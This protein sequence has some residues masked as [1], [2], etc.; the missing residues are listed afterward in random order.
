M[1]GGRQ[2]PKPVGS[3]PATTPSLQWISGHDDRRMGSKLPHAR[4]S[5]ATVCSTCC[6]IVRTSLSCQESQPWPWVQDG[7][8]GSCSCCSCRACELHFK[9]ADSSTARCLKRPCRHVALTRDSSKASQGQQPVTGLGDERDWKQQ[10]DLSS[11]PRRRERRCGQ[12]RHAVAIWTTCMSS[13]PALCSRHGRPITCSSVFP[14]VVVRNLD[15]NALLG[16]RL[17]PTSRAACVARDGN[18]KRDGLA[19]DALQAG[20]SWWYVERNAFLSH[21][22]A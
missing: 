18:G 21:L 22:S 12:P 7:L 17:C 8:P 10:C 20:K 9:H 15:V 6:S 16:G 11:I 1:G 14:A 5:D 4:C 19:S 13:H 3:R 2:I